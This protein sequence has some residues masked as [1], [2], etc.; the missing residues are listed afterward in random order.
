MLLSSSAGDAAGLT[1][2]RLGPDG[3]DGPEGRAAFQLEG[4]A[5]EE[6]EL[7]VHAA[8]VEVIEDGRGDDGAGVRVRVARVRGLHR[9]RAAARRGAPAR[10]RA[11]TAHLAVQLT[12]HGHQRTAHA[13]VITVTVTIT[14]RT[15]RTRVARAEL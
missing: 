10:G 8:R 2:P 3:V 4:R 6:V 5:G 11:E 1:R 13:I 14:I 12:R 7:E 9:G 15:A